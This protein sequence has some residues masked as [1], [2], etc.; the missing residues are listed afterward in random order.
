[1]YEFKGSNGKLLTEGLFYEFGNRDAP[2]TLRDE[3]H[4]SESGVT[5]TSLAQVY[6]NAVDEYDAV[7]RLGLSVRHWETLL[8]T[9]W[10]ESG[11]NLSGYSW[12]GV[13]ALRKEMAQ[14][15]AS[16]AKAQL[17]AAAAKG[18][19]PAMRALKEA[20]EKTGAGRPAKPKAKIEEVKL[21]D[22]APKAKDA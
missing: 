17:L 11:S 14:R 8:G 15:D 10:F 3:D 18:S 2:F 19:V 4:T 16:I 21:S 22:F 12:Q 1:M 7:K 5:Y 6:R 13:T 20:S 9:S